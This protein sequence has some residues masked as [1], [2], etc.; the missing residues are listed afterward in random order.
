MKRKILTLLMIALCTVTY[1]QQ[2]YDE[3]ID[4]IQQIDK[5]V[6]AAKASKKNV[7]CQVGGNWCPWCLRLI[8]HI[9]ADSLLSKTIDDNYIYIHV[10]YNPRKKSDNISSRQAGVLMKRLGQ[11]SR[12]GFPVLVVLN[13]EGNVIHTQDSSFLEEGNGYDSK[14]IMRFLKNWTPASIN[15]QNL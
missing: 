11:P 12:F 5:A 2:A 15:H 1:A 13:A 4:P 6:S 14:K 8:D 3:N 10:N 7:I 9:A